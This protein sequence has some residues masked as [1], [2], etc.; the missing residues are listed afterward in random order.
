MVGYPKSVIFFLQFCLVLMMLS[1]RAEASTPLA[2]PADQSTLDQAMVVTCA[3]NVA[4]QSVYV[5]KQ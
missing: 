4:R 3:S 2:C 1:A 5:F